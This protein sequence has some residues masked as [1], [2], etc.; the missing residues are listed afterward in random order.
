VLVV[1]VHDEVTH[2]DLVIELGA[3]GYIMKREAA[4]KIIDG[5]RAVLTG[6]FFLSHRA[7]TSLTPSTAK[8]VSGLTVLSGPW[9]PK[10]TMDEREA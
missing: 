2:A 3:R 10:R 5:I 6:S 1:S 7:I 8:I 9:I 4:E